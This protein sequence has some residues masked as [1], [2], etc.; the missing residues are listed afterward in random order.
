[1]RG[2]DVCIDVSRIHKGVGHDDAQTKGD[3][4]VE[5]ILIEEKTVIKQKLKRL[6]LFFPFGSG[7]GIRT[8]VD[9]TKTRSPTTRRSPNVD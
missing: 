4:M 5:Y 1:M 6:A 2:V 7:I 3:I 8:P 9:G